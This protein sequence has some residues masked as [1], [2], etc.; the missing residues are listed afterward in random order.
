MA[1]LSNLKKILVPVDFSEPCLKALHYALALA[2]HFGSQI[3][4]MHV[5]RKASPATRL[6]I[7]QSKSKNHLREE[8]NRLLNSFIKKHIQIK[9]NLDQT[10]KTGVPFNEIV[11]TAK[12]YN[13]DAIV[14]ATHGYSGL[15]HITMGSTAERVVRYAS[16]PVLVVREKEHDFLST[17]S[18][19][20]LEL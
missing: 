6:V 7:N 2:Q 12:R 5:I 4:L 13:V 1:S 9:V 3:I 17:K 11:N 20:P 15:K 10:I 14:I 8:A 18:K 19:K 16:C